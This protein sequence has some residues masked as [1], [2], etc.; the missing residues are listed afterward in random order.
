MPSYMLVFFPA[1]RGHT[2]ELTTIILVL[3][4]VLLV[5]IIV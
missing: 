4:I 1:P 5:L 3:L 2:V